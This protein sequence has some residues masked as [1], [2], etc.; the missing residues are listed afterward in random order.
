MVHYLVLYQG[1]SNGIEQFST[2]LNCF[3][4]TVVGEEGDRSGGGG[5]VTRFLYIYHFVLHSPS[6]S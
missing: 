6:L 5:H 3:G 4:D 1:I 2:D